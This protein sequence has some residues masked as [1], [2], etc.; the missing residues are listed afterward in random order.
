ML[1]LFYTAGVALLWLAQFWLAALLATLGIVI[2][3][4]QF[5]FYRELLDPSFPRQTGR[6]VLAALEPAGAGGGSGG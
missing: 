4:G 5:F 6:N 3:I 1:V 2:L